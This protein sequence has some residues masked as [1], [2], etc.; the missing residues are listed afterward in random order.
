M[1]R[2]GNRGKGTVSKPRIPHKYYE[3]EK[4]GTQQGVGFEYQGTKLCVDCLV[5]FLSANCCELKQ[6]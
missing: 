4:H 6:L 5:E 2:K 3:C 1:S